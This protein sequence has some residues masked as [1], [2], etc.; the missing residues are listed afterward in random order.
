MGKQIALSERQVR[1]V[2][3][4]SD[5]GSAIMQDLKSVLPMVSEDT[6]LRDIRDLMDKGIVHKKGRTKAARYYIGAQ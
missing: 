5:Q 4:L 1:L 6:V 3:Y 2:E